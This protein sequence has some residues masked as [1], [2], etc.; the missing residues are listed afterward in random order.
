ML[1][2]K[3]PNMK[4]GRSADTENSQPSPQSEPRSSPDVQPKTE[5]GKM[6]HCC[7]PESVATKQ[8]TLTSRGAAQLS[9]HSAGTHCILCMFTSPCVSTPLLACLVAG[10]QAALDIRLASAPSI[11][12]MGSAFQGSALRPAQA[13]VGDPSPI[14]P[15][16]PLAKRHRSENLD[17]RELLPFPRRVN[18]PLEE[19]WPAHGPYSATRWHALVIQ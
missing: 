18:P 12:G 13:L 10:N 19:L 1:S 7:M 5:L 11:M 2:G 4:R 3:L 9:R 6:C 14:M 16:T 8:S 17:A 15:P